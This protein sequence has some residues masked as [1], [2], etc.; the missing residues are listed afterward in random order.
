[1]KI[2]KFKYYF[3][4]RS[5]KIPVA[6][7]EG[8]CSIFYSLLVSLVFAYLTII[9]TNN[10]SW[11]GHL[12]FSLSIA[13][14]AILILF[15][16]DINRRMKIHN[17]KY[18]NVKKESNIQKDEYFFK[19]ETKDVEENEEKR[20]C[21]EHAGLYIGSILIIFLIFGGFA[22]AWN[23]YEDP[24]V[25]INQSLHEIAQKIEKAEN[26][27]KEN[28]CLKDS[29]IILNTKIQQLTQQTDSIQ[30]LID[31]QF[32]ERIKKFKKERKGIGLL[33]E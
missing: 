12:L 25:N 33:Q 19:A 21:T 20:H 32:N 16:M 27:S 11:E 24:T 10:L 1:M 18:K 8:F 28:C 30:K 7:F 23:T 17:E 22:W 31:I 14:C 2:I 4:H 6:F 29:I 3:V 9:S 5:S 15:S 13:L 26:L